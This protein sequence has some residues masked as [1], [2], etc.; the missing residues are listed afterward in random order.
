MGPGRRHPAPA[1]GSRVVLRFRREPG[2]VPSQSDALGTL[3]ALSPLVRVRTA[4]GAEVSV[5]PGRVV[6]LKSVPP[7]PVRRSAIRAV[8]FAIAWSRADVETAWVA[9]WVARAGGAA[10]TRAPEGAP[11][12]YPGGVDPLAAGAATPLADPAMPEGDFFHDLLDARTLDT[13]G[14]WFTGRGL[15]LTLRLPDRLVR[16]PAEWQGFA[17]HL[18]LT[19]DLP[20]S[21]AGRPAGAVA[22]AAALE[23]A[24]DAVDPAAGH[25]G[26]ARVRIGAAGSA[27]EAVAR[28]SE[29]SDGRVWAVLTVEAAE[30]G[31]VPA[32]GTAPDR[33]GAVET[34]AVETGAVEAGADDAGAAV[35]ALCRWAA[36]AG[37]SGAVLALHESGGVKGGDTAGDT[38]GSAGSSATSGGR[39]VRR[40]GFEDTVVRTL[41]F[42]DHH[43]CRYVR[44]RPDG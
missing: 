16:P 36:G 29:G 32:A 7:R 20:L 13:L 41:G 21:A 26:S 8:E 39:H 30:P 18:L 1:V 23:T 11:T 4:D 15:P 9:G 2:S 3:V 38:G 24:G 27:V 34:G 40:E 10:G 35:E 31:R 22:G 14:A 43:R 44:L 37:A 5:E 19:A 33:D 25:R 17:E 12:A 28:I 6:V 42:A